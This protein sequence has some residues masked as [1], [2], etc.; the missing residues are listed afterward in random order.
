MSPSI[1]ITRSRI[2]LV[3]GAG[4][5]H[6]PVAWIVAIL[7]HAGIIAATLVT[8]AHRLDITDES[9]PT[10][11]VDLVTFA[12]KTNVMAQTKEQKAPPKDRQVTPQPD[13]MQMPVPKPMPSPPTAE[14]APP[15]PEQAAKAEP[16]PTPKAKPQPP[17]PEKKPSTDQDFAAL[18]NKYSAP[19]ATDKNV[20]PGTRTVAGV[21]AMNAMTAELQSLLQSQIKECWSPPIGAP[22]PE[23][24]IVDFELFLNRD[25]SV[26]QPPQL[27]A[28]SAAATRGDP[29]M[30]AAAEAARRAIITCAPYKLPAD[31]YND[32][33]DITFTF[34][35]ADMV[36]GR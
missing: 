23:R 14:P 27:A 22:H 26:A 29:Y 15:K 31:H 11:P 30:L 16:T 7:L 3:S 32:W 36:N 13:Q 28:N 2:S 10:V 6:S 17:A 8:F 12:P 25:G 1:A 35:P 4:E 5:S 20:K 19:A 33:R 34:N 9:A 24:L 21:G 18:I